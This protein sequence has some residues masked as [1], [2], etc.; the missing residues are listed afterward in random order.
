MVHRSEW[1]VVLQF[2]QPQLAGHCLNHVWRSLMDL[3][4]QNPPLS[5]PLGEGLQSCK[6]DV[7]SGQLKIALEKH[8]V[9]I[10]TSPMLSILS[11]TWQFSIDSYV[12]L[13]EG[14]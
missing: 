3:A 9:D 2:D 4:G 8:H 1:E 11:F 13:L 14:K 6:W 7:S 5:H 12:F 10:S